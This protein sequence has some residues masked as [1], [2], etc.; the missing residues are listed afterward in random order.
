MKTIKILLTA[1]LLTAVSA[2][3]TSCD[4]DHYYSPLIGRWKVISETD[5]YHEF[6]FFTDGYG[7]YVTFGYHGEVYVDE[8]RWWDDMGLVRMRFSDGEVWNYE[9]EVRGN[10]MTLWNV[11]YGYYPME[12]HF[13][14]Y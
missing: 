6:E 13:K 7:N 10:Y 3:T 1:L 11:D 9:Y 4:D 8:F 14:G 12:Y 5:I 2:I